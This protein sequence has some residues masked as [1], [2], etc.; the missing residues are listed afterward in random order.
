MSTM[1][2]ISVR[3][4]ISII[5]AISLPPHGTLH[6]AGTHISAAVEQ[7]RRSQHIAGRRVGHTVRR[8]HLLAGIGIGIGVIALGHFDLDAVVALHVFV[9]VVLVAAA[10]LL[11]GSAAILA[12]QQLGVLLAEECD[13]TTCGVDDTLVAGILVLQTHTKYSRENGHSVH[14]S[15]ATFV[16]ADS[17]SPPPS[18]SMSSS[19]PSFGWRKDQFILR[20]SEMELLVL[21]Q[22]DDALCRA[23][24]STTKTKLLLHISTFV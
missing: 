8:L 16:W 1:Y 9:V 2:I 20:K 19:S 11:V 22:C 14:Q 5:S 23:S 21:R 17:A 18:P 15:M 7:Q 6:G 4:L 12:V 3:T 24:S 10:R 13:E